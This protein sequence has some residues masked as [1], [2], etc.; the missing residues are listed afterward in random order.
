[1]YAL[2]RTSHLMARL[3]VQ[4][5]SPVIST[6]KVMSGLPVQAKS[7]IVTNTLNELGSELPVQAKFRP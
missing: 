4:A 7:L 6:H 1:M 5:K 2:P 3:P